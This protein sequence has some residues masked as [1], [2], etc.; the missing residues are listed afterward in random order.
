MLIPAPLRPGDKVALVAPCSPVR[1]ERLAYAVDYIASLGYTP[2]VYPS[3][4]S[5]EGF[6]AGADAQRAA[7]LNRAFAD[8]SVR[9]V[10]VVRGGYGGARLAGLLDYDIIKSNPKLFCGFSDATVLHWLIG[11]RCGLATFHAPMPGAAN[12]P[13]D[14]FTRQSLADVLA[15]KWVGQP[16]NAGASLE[17]LFE[18]NAEGEL[19]GGNLTVLASTAGTSYRFSCDGGRGKILFLEDV[20]E[21]A[22]AIDRSLL[23]LRDSGMLRGC[24]G[25]LLGTWKDCAA[26]SDLPLREVFRRAFAPLG[27]PVIAGLPCGHS[28][29]SIALPLGFPVSM[30]ARADGWR[31]V[32]KEP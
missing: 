1:P 18:G 12:F 14:A 9:A 23:H 32:I 11:S 31:I 4:T 3:C 30:K 8:Q 24:R 27:I 15:G 19:V 7:D 17:C 20:G 29:P 6:L 5:R 21:Y 2:E 28:V 16:D 13:D 26:P 25:I 22:Y 10:V